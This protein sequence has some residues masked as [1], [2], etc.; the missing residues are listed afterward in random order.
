[1]QDGSDIRAQIRGGVAS[2]LVTGRE[3]RVSMSGKWPTVWPADTKR[4]IGTSWG[5]VH[6]L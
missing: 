2:A 6:V 3:V 4:L 1:M 5:Y